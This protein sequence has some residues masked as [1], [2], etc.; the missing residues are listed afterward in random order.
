MCGMLLFARCVLS[1]V[2]LCVCG[3]CCL[4]AVCCVLCVM[5]C[6]PGDV[7]CVSCDVCCGVLCVLSVAISAL[8]RVLYLL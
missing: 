4:C 6:L 1:D 5:C 7:C 8:L 2:I 3:V